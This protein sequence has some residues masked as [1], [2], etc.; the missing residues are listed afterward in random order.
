MKLVLCVEASH[1][2]YLFTDVSI[3]KKL[4]CPGWIVRMSTNRRRREN[5]L[6]NEEL[7]YHSVLRAGHSQ[8]SELGGWEQNWLSSNTAVR[9]QQQPE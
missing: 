3:L 2:I 9:L 4:G 1:A 5:H 8:K 7:Q 6:K